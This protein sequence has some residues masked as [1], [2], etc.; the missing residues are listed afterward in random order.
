MKK[1]FLIIILFFP[2]KSFAVSDYSTPKEILTLYSDTK[3]KPLVTIYFKGLG[4]GY[5]WYNT[6]LETKISLKLFCVPRNKS[7]DGE[8]FYAIYRS[9]Y[10]KNKEIYDSLTG[11]PPG[12]ILLQGM[13]NTYP[14]E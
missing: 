3:Y 13:I 8:D 1:I 4:S 7:F 11:Q 2:L 12:M 6:E 9:E 10:L 5:S 14:C